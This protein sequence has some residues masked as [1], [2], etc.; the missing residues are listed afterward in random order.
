M[1]GGDEERAPRRAWT[2]GPSRPP[3]SPP[4][5][6]RTRITLKL[7]SGTMA[8]PMPSYCRNPFGVS[9]AGERTNYLIEAALGGGRA[10]H[11]SNVRTSQHRIHHFQHSGPRR[12]DLHNFRSL[13]RDNVYQDWYLQFVSRLYPLGGLRGIR[14]LQILR[15]VDKFAP[16]KAF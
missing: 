13:Y 9:C 12:C 1:N 14:S 15:V 7:E 6:H 5:R 11:S 4:S 8:Y 16:H 3:S 10:D 2:G